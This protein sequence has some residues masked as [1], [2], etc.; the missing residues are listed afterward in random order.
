MNRLPTYKQISILSALVE[1]NSLRSISRM[2][3]IHRTTIMNLLIEAGKRALEIH[4]TYMNNIKS[5]QI[6][7]RWMKYGHS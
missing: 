2:F 1:G 4:D 5:N 7:F 3:D 6:L